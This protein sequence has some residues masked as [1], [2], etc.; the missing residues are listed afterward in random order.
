VLAGWERSQINIAPGSPDSNDKLV[1][2]CGKNNDGKE[3][4]MFAAELNK[5]TMIYEV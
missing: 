5:R 3:F 2:A 1:V 4:P